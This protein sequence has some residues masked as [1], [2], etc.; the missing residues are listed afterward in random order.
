MLHFFGITSLILAILT[1]SITFTINFIPL[2]EWTAES[3][4]LANRVG[5]SQDRLMQNYEKLIG[6]LNKPWV[7]TLNLPDFPSS[8][9]G[10]FHFYEV[11]RLFLLNYAILGISGIGAFVYLTYV[12]KTKQQWKLIQPFRIAIGV[13]FVAL[14]FLTVNFNRFFILFHELFF[15]NDDWIFNAATDPIILVLPEQ[16]FLYTFILAFGLLIAGFLGVYFWAKRSAFPQ[17]KKSGGA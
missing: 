11:K 3:L 12:Q 1:L 4:D 9:S 6:Y 7:G 2:Y 16:F 15:N 8:E 14:F 5:L 10:L 13:P 17:K